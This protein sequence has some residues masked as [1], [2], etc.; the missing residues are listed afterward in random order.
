MAGTQF[1]VAAGTSIHRPD[2]SAMCPATAEAAT[3][4]GEAR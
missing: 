3:V 4:A 1:S 2:A